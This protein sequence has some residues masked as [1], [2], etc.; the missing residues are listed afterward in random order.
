MITKKTLWLK[1][2]LIIICCLTCASCASTKNPLANIKKREDV[3][4]VHVSP[5][6]MWVMRSAVRTAAG[7]DAE[8]AMTMLKDIKSVDIVICDENPSVNDIKNIVHKELETRKYD[9]ALQVKDSKSSNVAFYS[10]THSKDS[11]VFKN[12]VIEVNDDDSYVVIYI[13][14][15][16][17]P[18]TFPLDDFKSG[19]ISI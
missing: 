12:P 13:N 1:S 2:I 10:R 14:G 6:L 5:F 11:A 18:T 7:D 19:N 8:P 9:I 4:A 17:D 3:E 16:I 15:K